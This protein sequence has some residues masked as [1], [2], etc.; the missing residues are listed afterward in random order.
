M[1]IVENT[2]YENSIPKLYMKV[3]SKTF[4]SNSETLFFSEVIKKLGTILLY[5]PE[6]INLAFSC[7]HQHSTRLH[8]IKLI[9][10][11]TFIKSH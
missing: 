10:T 4:R 6:A 2:S 7:I 8:I 11:N 3:H 5:L 9:K 1:K